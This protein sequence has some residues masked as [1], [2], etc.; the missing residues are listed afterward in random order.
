MSRAA[1]HA[2]IAGIAPVARIS[3]LASVALLG[4]LSLAAC[5][6][7][8][9]R[10]RPPLADQVSSGDR[11]PRQALLAELRSEVLEAYERDEPPEL[12]STV[13]PQV[14]A[15][16]IGVGPGDVLVDQELLNASSRWPLMIDPSTSTSARSKHLELH[17]AG[18]LSAGWI[19]DEVSW[20]VEICKRTLVIPLR[21]TAMYAR[22]GDRWVLAVEHLSTGAELPATG[23]LL[24]GR[25]IP[26]TEVSS[27][28]GDD[29]ARSVAA[30]LQAPIVA[31]PLLATLPDKAFP[32]KTLLIIGPSWS[33]EWHG[34][35][36]LGQQL[37]PGALA[38]EDR[39]IGVVGRVASSATIAY[40][41]GNLVATAA[42][43]AR[44]R[45]RA[46]FV[47]ERQDG[48]WVVMQGHVSLPVDDQTLARS[49]V[50]SAFD[51][52]NP[53]VAKCGEQARSGFSDA[54]A[55]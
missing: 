42:S 49:A 54:A 28:I 51:S 25:S 37:V 10:A 5:A 14:G 46:S 45:L 47:L 9:R 1:A 4:L 39:R 13:L 29:V 31:S 55:R 6:S 44:T 2:L 21:L 18:D 48:R 36:P 34:S 23:Q 40:W 3:R 33:Q 20:R 15:A 50:G 19:S 53:L 22:Q 11:D 32:D 41:V 16:R 24:I 38:I 7:P 27:A 43:G 30:T 26:S 52:L 12:E 35:D 8:P 17:L